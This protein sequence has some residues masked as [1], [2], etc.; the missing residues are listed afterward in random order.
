[1]INFLEKLFGE[2]GELSR[3]ISTSRAILTI[4]TLLFLLLVFS[5]SKL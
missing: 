4:C 2:K 1:M 3:D 5:Y